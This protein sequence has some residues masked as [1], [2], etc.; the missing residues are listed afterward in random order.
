MIYAFTL[1]IGIK[2]PVTSQLFE[3][4]VRLR[5]VRTSNS[6]QK[7]G[8]VGEHCLYFRVRETRQVF[9]VQERVTTS[10]KTH[11]A[12]HLRTDVLRLQN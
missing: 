6:K 11:L 8:V 10:V 9:R 5:G 3:N 12:V 4:A 1:N 7:S 2:T